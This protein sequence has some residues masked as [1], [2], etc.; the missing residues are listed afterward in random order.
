M[1]DG[2]GDGAGA[3]DDGDAGDSFALMILTAMKP[4]RAPGNS[5]TLNE[6][7]APVHSRKVCCSEFGTVTLSASKA[8]TTFVT[9]RLCKR[10]DNHTKYSHEH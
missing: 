5:S 1:G 7:S 9:S 4:L 3:D 2:D 8:R 10:A 6:P